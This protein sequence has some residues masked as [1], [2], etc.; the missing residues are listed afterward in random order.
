MNNV[1]EK[2]KHVFRFFDINFKELA[3]MF[4]RRNGKRA[5]LFIE[6]YLKQRK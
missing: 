1:V 5:K 6:S 3:F 4:G 2:H